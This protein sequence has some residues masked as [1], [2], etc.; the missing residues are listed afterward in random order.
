MKDKAYIGVDPGKSGAMCLLIPAINV[1]SFMDNTH[2]PNFIF[3][4][5]IMIQEKYDLQIIV[6]EKVHAIL[7]L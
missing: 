6:I 5:V 7:K 2:P 3:N 1:A 4:W